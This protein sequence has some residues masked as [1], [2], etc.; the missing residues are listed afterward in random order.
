MKKAL[1]IFGSTTGNTEDMTGIIKTALE[2]SGLETEVKE[3]TDAAVAD[4]MANHELLLL[5][6][7]AY[8]DD[9]ID[10]QL[11]IGRVN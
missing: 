1:I 3:V 2:E 11:E 4:L 7:P 10:W 5:G 9:T 6:C 8:G